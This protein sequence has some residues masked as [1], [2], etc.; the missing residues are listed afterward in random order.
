MENVIIKDIVRFA[1]DADGLTQRDREKLVERHDNSSA[2]NEAVAVFKDM[3][4]TGRQER[5][6]LK[7]ISALDRF[8]LNNLIET[9]GR[10]LLIRCR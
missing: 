6:H 5:E 1:S 7:A 3:V 10:K 9:D 2:V 4:V 8:Q